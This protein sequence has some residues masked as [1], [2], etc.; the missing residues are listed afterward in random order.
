MTQRI[1]SRATILCLKFEMAF[2]YRPVPLQHFVFPSGAEG[3]YLVVDQKGKFRE[4]NFQKAMSTLQPSEMDEKTGKL[5]KKKG[6][7]NSS[8]E[9]FKIVR[10]V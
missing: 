2:A 1:K 3:L 6:G 9:L 5:A 10:C 4:E 7:N 8:A